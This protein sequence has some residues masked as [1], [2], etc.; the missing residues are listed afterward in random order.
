M[1]TSATM[2]TSS[3]FLAAGFMANGAREYVARSCAR[4]RCDKSMT[5]WF[6]L[7]RQKFSKSRHANLVSRMLKSNVELCGLR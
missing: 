1:V 4:P 7:S 3:D 5:V 6:A 2:I